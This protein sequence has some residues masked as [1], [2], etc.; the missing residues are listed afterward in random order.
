MLKEDIV[1]SLK[2]TAGVIIGTLLAKAFQMEFYTSVATIVIVS[3]LSAKKQSIKLAFIRLL[4]AIFSLALATLLFTTLGFKFYVF[5]LYILIFTFLMHKFN[6]K[7]AIVLNV[8]LVMHIYSLKEVSIP[9]LV[10]EFE[11]MFLGIV[12]A[13]GINSFILDIE[14]EL[15]GYQKKVESLFDSIFIKMGRC[16]Q[17]ECRAEVVSSELQQLDELLSKAKQRAYNYMNNYYIQEN[18]YYV[19]YFSMRKEQ[20]YTASAMQDFLNLKYLNKKEVKLLKDFTDNFVSNNEIMNSYESQMKALEEIKYH[21]T[22]EAV[23]PPTL[24]QLQNRIALHQFLYSLEDL[25]LIKKRFAE[26]YEKK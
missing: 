19:E 8:V 21:F 1:K 14:D 15:I 6:T 10:N 2:I 5:A 3:M 11:L 20:F 25:V 26:R 12:V 23:I 16:L 17:N 13:L 22:N 4:A 18:N 24:D 7:V 9:I